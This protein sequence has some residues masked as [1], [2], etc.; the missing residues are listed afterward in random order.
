MKNRASFGFTLI[1]L[2]IVVVIVAILAAVAYPAFTDQVRKSRRADAK[3]SLEALRLEQEKW[4]AN[5]RTYGAVGDV[6]SGTDSLDGYYTIAVA[7]NNAA[8]FTATATP[9]DDQA[10]DSC[11]TFAIDQSG[12]DESGD[13]AAI[14][15]CW[16]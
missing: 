5:H 13:Y 6:W 11:G 15:G 9:K 1:E 3:T 4:R 10:N 8:G 16:R 2:M 14:T 12:P 7:G